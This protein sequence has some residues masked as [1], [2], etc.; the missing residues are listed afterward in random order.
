MGIRFVCHQ[1][2]FA[3]HVKDFQAG[4]RGKCPNCKCSFRI[5]AT[6]SSYSTAIEDSEEDSGVASIREAFKKVKNSSA[7][8]LAEKP[9]DSV[10]ISLELSSIQEK[11]S[12]VSEVVSSPKQDAKVRPK[13]LPESASVPAVLA[14]DGGAKWFVRPPS[15][16]QFGPADSDLLMSWIGESR[17]TSE[18]FLWREGMEQWQ[19]AS[20]LL[21]ELFQSNTDTKVPTSVPPLQPPTTASFD[22]ADV[23]NFDIGLDGIPTSAMSAMLK[24]RMQKRRRQLT[25]VIILAT[26]SLILLSILIFVL[27]FR[28]T[29]ITPAPTAP[30]PTASLQ[31]AKLRIVRSISGIGFQPVVLKMTGWKPIPLQKSDI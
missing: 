18:S 8:K 9:S 10:A 15:G 31:P 20:E 4:K 16:G 24:K 7:T 12:R 23:K 14:V 5:P 30:A 25:M 27:V 17:V 28:V 26:L 11:S 22:D 13:K 3:L 19:L 29:T 6:D 1:C 21:P 2:G